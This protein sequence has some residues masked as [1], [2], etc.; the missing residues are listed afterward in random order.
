MDNDELANQIDK[1]ITDTSNINDKIREEK[2]T[3]KWNLML[4]IK[5]KH[6]K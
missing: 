5:E 1:T 4:E 2:I 6:K 3:N